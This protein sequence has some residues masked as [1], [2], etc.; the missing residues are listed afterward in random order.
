MQQTAMCT[1]MSLAARS[2]HCSVRNP[3]VSSGRLQRQVLKSLVSET[4]MPAFLQ[5]VCTTVLGYVQ[6]TEKTAEN[7]T[8]QC[9]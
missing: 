1:T 3:S 9:L 8:L 2:W 4:G 5:Y 6:S 7:G